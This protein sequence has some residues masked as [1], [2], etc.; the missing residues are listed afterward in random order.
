MIRGKGGR[1]SKNISL[2]IF[3]PPSDLGPIHPEMVKTCIEFERA[4]IIKRIEIPEIRKFRRD[5]YGFFLLC[6]TIEDLNLMTL[7]FQ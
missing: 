1:D 2:R 4:L 7:C 3:N 6:L 5:G